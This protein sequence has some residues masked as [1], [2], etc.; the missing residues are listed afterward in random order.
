ML[1]H[2][3]F[4]WERE[5]EREDIP[6]PLG[7][8]WACIPPHPPA[9]SRHP[10]PRQLPGAT[11]GPAPC[12]SER[13]LAARPPKPS[14]PGRGASGSH[15]YLLSQAPREEGEPNREGARGRAWFRSSGFSAPCRVE[16]RAA[17]SPCLLARLRPPSRGSCSQCM[18]LFR[19]LLTGAR[20]LHN[21]PAWPTVMMK[22]QGKWVEKPYCL[23]LF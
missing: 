17:P 18:N 15:A 12:P 2:L 13:S 11:P 23:Y 4:S 5:R 6:D 21:L 9:L 20:T 8:R 22:D 10:V 16:R 19:S 14:P 7:F 1:Q 3:C